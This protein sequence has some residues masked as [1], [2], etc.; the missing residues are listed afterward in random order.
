MLSY[1]VNLLVHIQDFNTAFTPIQA[2]LAQD[3]AVWKGGD[4]A[5]GLKCAADPQICI[6]ELS[7]AER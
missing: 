1:L 3:N 5:L 6:R 4:P 7:K 2:I